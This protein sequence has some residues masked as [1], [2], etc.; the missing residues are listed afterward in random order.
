MD[1]YFQPHHQTRGVSSLLLHDVVSEIKNNSKI[2]S[3]SKLTP[4]IPVFDRQASGGEFGIKQYI[5][6]SQVALHH[7][8]TFNQIMLLCKLLH[9]KLA[10][11][12]YRYNILQ[13]CLRSCPSFSSS[14]SVFHPTD[15][16]LS[17][18]HRNA[19]HASRD[20]ARAS[21]DGAHASR[22]GAHVLCDGG[23]PRDGI[24]GAQSDCHRH[25]EVA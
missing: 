22:G 3:N 9:D 20:G 10:S 6:A 16:R 19:S 23:G 4:I 8:T 2:L 14:T 7:I 24:C 15:P 17:Q 21:R 13:Q 25:R 11:L 5:T 1:I 12:H 18:I